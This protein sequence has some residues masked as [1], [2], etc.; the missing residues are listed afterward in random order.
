MFVGNEATSQSGLGESGMG[1]SLE[2]SSHG[3]AWAL[4]LARKIR[5][6]TDAYNTLTHEL[7]HVL[8]LN[9]GTQPDEIFQLLGGG[10]P[11]HSALFSRIR[12]NAEQI[13]W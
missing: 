13:G 1:C 6:K 11:R 3:V 10:L 7:G 5:N 8:G 4:L 12:A 9:H 2:N